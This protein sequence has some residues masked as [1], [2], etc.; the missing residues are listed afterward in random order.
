MMEEVKT[1]KIF[2]SSSVSNIPTIVIDSG[3]T[4]EVNL[5]NTRLERSFVILP[6][7]RFDSSCPQLDLEAGRLTRAKNET[8]LN[9]IGVQPDSS[10]G[11]G[12]SFGVGRPMHTPRNRIS[13]VREDGRCML[14]TCASVSPIMHRS[15]LSS[16]MS[17]SD[18]SVFYSSKTSRV[19]EDNLQRSGQRSLLWRWLL[20]ISGGLA[21]ISPLGLLAIKN[22]FIGTLISLITILLAL[23]TLVIALVKMRLS[24]SREDY[25]ELEGCNTKILP[26]YTR[27]IDTIFEDTEISH[28]KNSTATSKS[29]GAADQ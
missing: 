12:V 29:D 6:R 1:P 4:S 13:S 20:N 27:N 10:V 25:S 7:P 17:T 26:P 23:V 8:S 11:G 3:Q 19:T 16:E 24:N 28:Q 21:C 22:G 5:E 2:A 15:Q 9:R 18:G 14:P